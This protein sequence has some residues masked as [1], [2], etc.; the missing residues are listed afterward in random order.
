MLCTN[1]ALGCKRPSAYL[2]ESKPRWTLLSLCL[3]L[4]C[5]HHIL[6]NPVKCNI[7]WKKPFQSKE[8]LLRLYVGTMSHKQ[9]FLSPSSA[10]FLSH[11]LLS[12]LLSDISSS[13]SVVVVVINNL[14]LV[15]DLTFTSPF[16]VS[17]WL[18]P[19]L[20]PLP[21]ASLRLGCTCSDC[22]GQG[23]L[24]SGTHFLLA[25]VLPL[26]PVQYAWNISYYIVQYAWS[27]LYY[28]NY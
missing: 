14:C 15:Q 18:F 6:W 20:P 5:L 17:A 2:P 3:G 13:S 9:H 16:F 28:I 8:Y 10:H 21:L 12:L 1:S 22:L 4:C 24:C 11:L 7:M 23:R 25:P 27:I 26:T 19:H